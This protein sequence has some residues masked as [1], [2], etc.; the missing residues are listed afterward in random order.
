MPMCAKVATMGAEAAT[1]TWSERAPLSTSAHSRG[2][3]K[4]AFRSPRTS[5]M[6]PTSCSGRKATT[7]GM[8]RG[9]GWHGGVPQHPAEAGAAV[10]VGEHDNSCTSST[11]GN[12]YKIA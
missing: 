2:Q 10:E 8:L 1:I 3:S 12:F 4:R 11:N 7:R 5:V 6:S 9:W